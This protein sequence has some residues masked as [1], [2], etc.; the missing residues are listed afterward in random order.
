LDLLKD[1]IEE[2]LCCGCGTCAGVCPEDAIQMQKTDGLYQPRID[3][4]KCI[5]CT[6]CIRSCPGHSVDFEGISLQV[7]NAKYKNDSVG[8]HLSCYV[9]YSTDDTIRFNSSSGGLITQLLIFALENN[10]ID[11]VITTRMSKTDPLETEPFIART[12][13]EIVEASKSK[14]CPV[15]SNICLKDVLKENGRFAVVGLPCHI[16]GIR[17]AE[18]LNKELKKKIILKFGLLCSHTVDF[19]GTKFILN[20]MGLN[21][22]E[23]AEITYRGNGWPGSMVIR[24]K[25]GANLRLPLVGSWHAYWMVFSSFFFTPMR[26]TMCPDQA[27]ELADISF[28]DAWLPEF[29]NEKIGMSILVSRTRIGDSLISQANEAKEVSVK[30]VGIEKIYQSQRVNMKIKKSDLSFRLSALRLLGLATPK[31]TP[32]LSSQ[33]SIVSALRTFYMY[34]NIRASSNRRFQSLLIRTPLPVIRLYY[35]IYRAL[36]L[37]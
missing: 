11:G 6:L 7:F 34:F 27:A 9:G 19:K 26:C 3:E 22:N 36:S 8:N 32:S 13:T 4:T 37:I 17:K 31:F 16:H 10:I 29:N 12:R 20:K 24:T 14:Y 35:G 28:G 15:A 5:N 23:I 25:E 1:V 2:G 18:Q 21:E 33:K 30:C